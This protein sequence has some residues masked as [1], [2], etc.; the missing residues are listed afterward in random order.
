MRI[1][2]IVDLVFFHV[3]HG[4]RVSVRDMC[5]VDEASVLCH[6]ADLP[7]NLSPWGKTKGLVHV[8]SRVVAR[9]FLV[10]GGH[11]AK[12]SEHIDL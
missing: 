10:P 5:S 3:G 7:T 11:L 4:V 6:N 2:Q 8:T 12:R 9:A 1:A